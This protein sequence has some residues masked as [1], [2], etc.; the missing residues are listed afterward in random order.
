MGRTGSSFGAGPRTLISVEDRRTNGVRIPKPTMRGGNITRHKSQ[1]GCSCRHAGNRL[2]GN[3]GVVHI[4]QVRRRIFSSRTDGTFANTRKASELRFTRMSA[5]PSRT[6]AAAQRTIAMV[7]RVEPSLGNS[8]DPRR[9]DH[10]VRSGLA[11]SSVRRASERRVVTPGARLSGNHRW[12]RCKRLFMIMAALTELMSRQGAALGF[13]RERPWPAFPARQRN[14]SPCSSR[15]RDWVM[16]R[17]G[18]L[19]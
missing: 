6:L 7:S 10:V 8:G 16:E 17:F 18:T 13:F 1:S 5:R 4:P 15:R 9:F 12:K 2:G 14:P 11:R 3:V 19:R